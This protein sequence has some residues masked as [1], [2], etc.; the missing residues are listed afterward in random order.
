MVARIMGHRAIGVDSDP[1]AVL[2]SGTWGRNVNKRRL[3]TTA[4]RV[5]ATARLS[6]R[7]TPASRAYPVDADEETRAFV[8]FWFDL[9]ARRQLAALSDAIR[10]LH[11][12]DL[13]P[14]LWCA[15]SRLIITKD[16]GASRALDVSHSRPHRAFEL[17]PRRP[18]DYFLRAVTHV[19]ERAPFDADATEPSI[20]VHRGDARR[21][22]IPANS[23]DAVVTS[24]PYLNAIDY[25]RGHRLALVWM[26]RQIGDLRNIRATN[27]GSERA[28]VQV[29]PGYVAEAAAAA[30]PTLRGRGR[31]WFQRYAGDM[32]QVL[33]EVGRVLRDNGR[34]V[35]VAG[36]SQTQRKAVRN[37]VLIA[38]L[39]A[40]HELR[41]VARHRR[42]LPPNR[43]YLP[44]PGA[45]EAN[46]LESRLRTE[47]VLFFTR[48]PRQAR[49]HIRHRARR[50]GHDSSGGRTSGIVRRRR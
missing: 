26:G 43:R 3:L 44:P 22:R 39:A 12:S 13:K 28:A 19:A 48:L 4:S 16:A 33:A 1:L 11:S 9:A 35:L 42:R 25:L 15:L 37:S 31:D 21:L 24:P 23:V 7:V 40:S 36:D 32:D 47:V 41:L 14:F 5:L 10:A 45:S 20:E 18:F 30:A 50:P 34:A 8:R 46:A 29:P 38:R 27:I 6:A 49:D 17:G 2:V